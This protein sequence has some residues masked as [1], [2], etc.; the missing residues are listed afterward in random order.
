MRESGG[1][2]RRHRRR[3]W[4]LVLRSVAVASP[5]RPQPPICKEMS[6][7]D[8]VQCSCNDEAFPRLP[9]SPRLLRRAPLV[10]APAVSSSVRVT[11]R[12]SLAFPPLL[13]LPRRAPLVV[14]P[15]VSGASLL[16]LLSRRSREEKED[17]GEQGGEGSP[18]RSV[19]GGV[20]ACVQFA[21][22]S[23]PGVCLPP[24]PSLGH[25]FLSR[26][27]GAPRASITDRQ[28]GRVEEI[29]QLWW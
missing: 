6:R 27:G 2:L 28:G 29:K 13:G 4:P 8:E 23:S 15:A 20:C 1:E 26:D 11:T 24:S 3:R 25:S 22:Q 9:P 17:D 10:V 18:P 14:A 21:V 19:V 16:L 7:P 12:P 5:L